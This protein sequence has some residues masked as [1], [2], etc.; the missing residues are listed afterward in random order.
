MKLHRMFRKLLGFGAEDA[1]QGTHPAP[2]PV[3]PL[4]SM[5]DATGS[6]STDDQHMAILRRRIDAKPR[7]TWTD[8][9]WHFQLTGGLT[10][11]LAGWTPSRRARRPPRLPPPFARMRKAGYEELSLL[12]RDQIWTL[13]EARRQLGP[14][15]PWEAGKYIRVIHTGAGRGVVLGAQGYRLLGL[16]PKALCGVS[17]LTDLLYL[18]AAAQHHHWTL[19]RLPSRRHGSR[20]GRLD[21]LA[22]ATRDGRTVRVLARCTDGGYS[23]R[24]VRTLFA[25]LRSSLMAADTPLIVVTP[26]A[27]GIGRHEHEE[28]LQTVVFPVPRD[29]PRSRAGS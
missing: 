24:T 26:D 2:S 9:E 18:R 4:A 16:Q 11:N 12:H 28:Y 19:V 13:A 7:R 3:L 10:G 23:R 25:F 1:G 27:R 6:T 15:K 17:L 20:T 29:A 21:R 5:S 14:L 22:V 8:D